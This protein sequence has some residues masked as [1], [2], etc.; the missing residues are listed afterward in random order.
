MTVGT[1]DHNEIDAVVE[2]VPAALWQRL[3]H[4]AE[5]LGALLATAAGKNSSSPAALTRHAARMRPS[6]TSAM[7]ELG[8][9]LADVLGACGWKPAVL[10]HP[11]LM[12]AMFPLASYA[13]S[14]PPLVHRGQA[15]VSHDDEGLEFER[16]ILADSRTSFDLYSM[17]F[18]TYWQESAQARSFRA[19]AVA[20]SELVRAEINRRAAAGSELVSVAS[21]RCGGGFE[22]EPLLRDPICRRVMALTVVDDNISALRRIGHIVGDSL[23]H[24]PEY[25]RRDPY[26]PIEV[27]GWPLR[28]FDIALTIRMFDLDTPEIA[29]RMLHKG[30]HLLKPGGV[31]LGGLH[32]DGISLAERALSFVTVGVRVNCFSR[33]T[34]L[35]MLQTAGFRADLVTFTFKEPATLMFSAYAEASPNR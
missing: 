16:L 22:L 34:W 33:E 13:G 32:T 9:A 23:S 12:N 4:Q 1:E 35:N 26:A 17:L 31:L 2:A 15:A 19:R 7:N 29:V 30:R 20:I 8:R 6:F 5:E 10:S 18:S 24:K 3:R 28:K 14:A 27:R 11:T 25:I 21:V